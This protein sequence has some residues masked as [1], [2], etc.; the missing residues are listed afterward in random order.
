[1][2]TVLHWSARGQKCR[3]DEGLYLSASRFNS[4]GCGL[5]IPAVPGPHVLSPLIPQ[6]G[7]GGWIESA[8]AQTF[9]ASRWEIKC[10]VTK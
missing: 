1:M 10:K 4:A 8:R 6:E 5:D 2:T 7:R 9:F 3:L